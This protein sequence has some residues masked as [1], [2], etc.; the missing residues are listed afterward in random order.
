MDELNILLLLT[1]KALHNLDNFSPY[2]NILGLNSP[3]E[4]SNAIALP[5]TLISTLSNW[6]YIED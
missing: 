1:E 6:M 4:F 2:N 3:N 5:K